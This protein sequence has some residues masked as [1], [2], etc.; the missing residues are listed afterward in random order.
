MPSIDIIKL[1]LERGADPTQRFCN[2]TPFEHVRMKTAEH[3]F[4]DVVTMSHRIMDLFAEYTPNVHSMGN[5]KCSG[6]CVPVERSKLLQWR[7][8][9]WKTSMKWIFSA[10]FRA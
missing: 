4:A 3:S 9:R 10:K 5:V 1:L 8:S 2:T 7:R 6:E